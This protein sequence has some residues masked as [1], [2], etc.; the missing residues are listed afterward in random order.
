MVS[1]G[2]SMIISGQTWLQCTVFGQRTCSGE[3]GAMED[4]NRCKCCALLLWKGDGAAVDVFR[5]SQR[6]EFMPVPMIM[7][8]VF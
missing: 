2:L 1:K 4:R 3:E 8:I 5:H 7:K 6:I